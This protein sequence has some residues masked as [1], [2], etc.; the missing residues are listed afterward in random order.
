M[1]HRSLRPTSLPAQPSSENAPAGSTTSSNSMM[2]KVSHRFRPGQAV[3]NFL[4]R[5]S[6][7]IDGSESIRIAVWRPMRCA[8]SNVRACPG[9]GGAG[10]TSPPRVAFPAVPPFLFSPPI[11]AKPSGRPPF[12]REGG[13]GAFRPGGFWRRAPRALVPPLPCG[14]VQANPLFHPPR[15]G[16]RSRLTQAASQSCGPKKSSS[17]P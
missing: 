12:D 9:R 4:R 16:K 6:H 10:H 17:V 14:I 5:A 11:L 1:R 8:Q 13:R 3:S 15:T 7:R 2:A